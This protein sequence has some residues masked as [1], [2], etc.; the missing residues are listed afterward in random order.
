VYDYVV[1]RG[2]E[3]SLTVASRDLGL[4]VEELRRSTERLKKKRL[5]E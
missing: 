1:K 3:I 4:P 2:G 5:L